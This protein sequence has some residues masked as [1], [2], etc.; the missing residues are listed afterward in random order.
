MAEITMQ[1]RLRAIA[2]WLDAN[3]SAEPSSVTVYSDEARIFNFASDAKSL[4]SSALSIGGRWGKG[5]T[6]DHF[7]LCQ[8]VLPGVS[9]ELCSRRE[10]VCERVVV[11]TEKVTEPA[12][13]APMVEV[14]REIVEYR[15]PPSLLSIGGA[16]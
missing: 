9:Y 7:W 16:S 12:P 10:A 4:A 1:A 8:E 5:G 11:G 15:C 2:D 14:V 13:D 6:D 3:P